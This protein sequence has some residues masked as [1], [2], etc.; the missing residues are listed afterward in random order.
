MVKAKFKE[1]DLEG[2]FSGTKES[3]W[4]SKNHHIVKV[5]NRDIDDYIEYDYYMSEMFPNMETEEHLLESFECF[6]NDVMC[7]DMGAEEFYR[8]FAYD[9]DAGKSDRM[10][11]LC[12]E[13]MN[14]FSEIYEG[15]I[16]GL[17]DELVYDLYELYG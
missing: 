14:S 15:D 16:Y 4:G 11:K 13:S 3:T 12:V 2:R 8:E 7:G 10:Y 1:F 6:L 5:T 17:Y 9:G